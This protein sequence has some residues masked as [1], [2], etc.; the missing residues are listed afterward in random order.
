MTGRRPLPK[1]L[2]AAPGLCHLCHLCHAP[3]LEQR[4]ASVMQ[5]KGEWRLICRLAGGCQA[6]QRV[7][8]ER[9]DSGRT[10]VSD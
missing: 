1:T 2:P 8:E 5:I 10:R 3:L 7:L 6:R 9:G 4:D